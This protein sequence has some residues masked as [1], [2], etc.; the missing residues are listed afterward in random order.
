M[1]TKKEPFFIG[2]SSLS[3]LIW[4]VKRFFLVFSQKVRYSGTEK[5]W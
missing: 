1:R 5:E 4:E 3:Q 2:I